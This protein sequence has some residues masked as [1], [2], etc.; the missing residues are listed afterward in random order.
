MSATQ[1]EII[2]LGIFDDTAH[3]P[4]EDK[5][6]DAARLYSERFGTQATL[7]LISDH[8]DGV[9]VSIEGLR[10]Q[11]AS[12]VRPNVYL[13]GRAGAWAMVEGVAGEVQV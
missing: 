1:E 11:V 8:E 2:Y 6:R 12:Y 9:P 7:C 13:V 5:L 10:V 4:L 3:K